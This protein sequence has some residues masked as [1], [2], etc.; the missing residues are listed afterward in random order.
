MEKGFGR[1]MVRSCTAG[2][3]NR[4]RCVKGCREGEQMCKGGVPGVVKRGNSLKKRCED[5]C[6][7]VEL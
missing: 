5:K 2:V 7:E 3:S 6:Q 1:E 4:V